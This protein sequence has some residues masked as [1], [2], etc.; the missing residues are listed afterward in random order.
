MKVNTLGGNDELEPLAT[1]SMKTLN[2][3]HENFKGIMEHSFKERSSDVDSIEE[4]IKHAS[5]NYG[6]L[7]ATH[8]DEKLKE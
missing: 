2:E 5:R 1:G 6:A 3:R 8:E 7:E 4:R